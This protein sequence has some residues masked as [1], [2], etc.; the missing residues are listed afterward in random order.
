MR[1]L[2]GWGTIDS[3]AS[4]LSAKM[5]EVQVVLCKMIYKYCNIF[6]RPVS[7][8][9]RCLLYQMKSVRP[10]AALKWRWAWKRAH[11]S[12]STYNVKWCYM[13]KWYTSIILQ[14]SY[15]GKCITT[16]SSYSGRIT[17]D[18]L[19][20]GE[21]GKDACQV[22]RFCNSLHDLV[23]VAISVKAINWEDL[24]LLWIW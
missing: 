5:R 24:S 8:K 16:S 3:C 14:V 23:C 6:F 19:C 10:Q 12:F 20:A 1:L 21:A 15:L 22:F 7:L 18:M 11:K 2:A 13:S 4:S 17:D 9:T